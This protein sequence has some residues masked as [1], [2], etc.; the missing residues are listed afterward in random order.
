MNCPHKL[1]ALFIPLP[2]YY[3]DGRVEC[4][5]CETFSTAPRTW[6]F[7]MDVFCGELSKKSHKTATAD[8]TTRK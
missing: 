6:S 4:L 2:I 7:R 1:V 3:G 8:P 5:N